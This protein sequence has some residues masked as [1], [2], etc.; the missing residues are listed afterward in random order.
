MTPWLFLSHHHEIQICG[1]EWNAY[2]AI[3]RIVTVI[4]LV[5]TFMLPSG[6]FVIT[7]VSSSA[8]ILICVILYL[9]PYTDKAKDILIRLSCCLYL[10]LISKH[11][12][13]NMLSWDVLAFSSLP[14][15]SQ[16]NRAASMAVDSFYALSHVEDGMHCATEISLLC[17]WNSKFDI[18]IV[19]VS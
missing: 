17:N 7:L 12:H 11:W 16:S 19:C 18:M 15:P 2:K 8:N 9:W 3:G 1:F 14:H 4:N 6:W 5:Q 10:V 13:A